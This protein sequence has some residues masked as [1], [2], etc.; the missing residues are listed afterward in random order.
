MLGKTTGYAIR[1]LVYVYMQNIKGKRP[2]YKEISK[3]TDSPE[4]FTAKVL[5]NLARA[6]LVSSMKGRGGGF[7]FDE[8]ANPITSL[9]LLNSDDFTEMR[10]SDD[11]IGYCLIENP[12]AFNGSDKQADVNPDE[13]SDESS[14]NLLN[15]LKIVIEKYG[16][17][18]SRPKDEE[19][20]VSIGKL[21]LDQI[22]A[23]RNGEQDEAEFWLEKGGKFI[24][25][26]YNAVRDDQGNFRGGGDDA[27]CYT[28][29]QINR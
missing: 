20:D 2:G 23:F 24:Y 16:L 10:I 7:F 22:K 8:P 4:Q 6:E 25:I 9:K 27:G 21:T 5:Q 19:L 17:S 26:I 11:E 1:A 18:G 12:P 28:Y 29:S 14:D 13:S 15:D 3:E